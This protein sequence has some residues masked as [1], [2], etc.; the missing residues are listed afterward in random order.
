VRTPR[1]QRAIRQ[2]AESKYSLI[3]SAPIPFLAGMKFSVL[4]FAELSRKLVMMH[5]EGKERL[6]NNNI[7]EKPF[8]RCTTRC[9]IE[10]KALAQ[11]TLHFLLNRAKCTKGF[12]SAGSVS[13]ARSPR[14]EEKRLKKANG[15]YF[16]KGQTSLRPLN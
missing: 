6:A 2:R 9:L 4:V 15:E 7:G 14:K 5:G 12:Y 13:P 8:R 3:R 11:H 1:R 16:G 10:K